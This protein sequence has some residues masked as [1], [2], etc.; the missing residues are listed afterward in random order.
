M[1]FV[2]VP[3][4]L[5][6]AEL[7]THRKW[8]VKASIALSATVLAAFL[9]SLAVQLPRFSDNATIYASALKVAPSSLLARAYYAQA[10]WDYGHREESLREFT[11]LTEMAPHSPE[12]HESYGTV[13][14]QLGRENEA[15]TEFTTALQWTPKPTAFRALVLSEVAQIELNRSEF[16]EATDHMREAVQIEPQ[17]LNYHSLLAQALTREGRIN[18]ADEE[19]KLEASVRQ[20]F[21]QDHRDSRD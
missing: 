7:L 16:P 15:M 18:E 9:V 21:I 1:Y 5:I 4:C 10:L 6:V 2:S 3:V 14:A 17:T 19:T 8:P 20:R 13:L 12:I 11:I